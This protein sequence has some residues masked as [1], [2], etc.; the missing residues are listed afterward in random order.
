MMLQSQNI[1][2]PNLDFDYYSTGP[3]HGGRQRVADE[4]INNLQPEYT[5]DIRQLVPGML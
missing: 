5:N 1:D 4:F 2:G 3:S